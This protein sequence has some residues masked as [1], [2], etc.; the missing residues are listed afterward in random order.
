MS[1]H[2][3]V[4]KFAPTNIKSILGFP[5]GIL[6]ELH[7]LVRCMAMLLLPTS[8]TNLI[9]GHDQELSHPMTNCKLQRLS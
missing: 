4:L 8:W 9:D 5:L 3:V 7:I 2:N 1:C 6:I